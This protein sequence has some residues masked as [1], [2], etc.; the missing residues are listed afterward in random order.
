MLKLRQQSL[1]ILLFQRRTGTKPPLSKRGGGDLL[2]KKNGKRLRSALPL[3]TIAVLLFAFS[4]RA[5]DA[6]ENFSSNIRTLLFAD[7]V[8]PANSTQ[9]PDNAFLRLP[10]YSGELHFRPDLFWDQP[11][12]NVL[13]KPRFTSSYRWWEDGTPDCRKDG[14]SRAFVNEWR[15]QGKPLST[16]F[17]SFGK[18][19]ML[20]GPSFLADPSNILFNNTEKINP[21][22]EIEG[23][24][25]AKLIFIPDTPATVTVGSETQKEKAGLGGQVMPLRFVKADVMGSNYAISAIGY[26]R[27][28]DRL[29][30]GS[31]G[32]WTASDALVLYYDGLVTRGTDALYPA[33]DSSEPVGGTFIKKYGE[34]GRLFTTVSAGGS[35][36]FLSGSTMSLEFL[37]NGKGYSG[38]EAEDYYRLRQSAADQLFG[39]SPLSA[40]SQKT[41]AEALNNGQ[42]FLRKYYLMAQYQFREIRNAADLIV[43][44]LY[45]LEEHAGQ[46]STILEW[47][48]TNNMQFFNINNISASH[49]RETE[50]KAVTD[51]SFMAGIEVYF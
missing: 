38:A 11:D 34:S 37:Y 26:I 31:Y 2:F 28:H 40:L 13:F 10:R 7:V 29:R 50:F 27:Q 32:Q 21:K 6:A 35:Y 1:S 33:Q 14:L 18:E 22:R 20:W 19:K 3:A 30:L 15:I 36:T 47:Q 23:K 41:L 46:A 45:G 42:P 9:N 16:I 44:Y 48:L 24:Y 17:L 8:H 5:S 49:A 51:K 4:V 12:L 39:G 43:R 25:L